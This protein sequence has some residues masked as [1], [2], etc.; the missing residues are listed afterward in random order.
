M[1][2]NTTS[3]DDIREIRRLME[4][5]SRFLSLSGLSG[6]VAGLIALLGAGAAWWYLDEGNLSSAENFR[7]MNYP[8]NVQVI[9][10]LIY[11]ALIVLALALLSG[12]YFSKRKAR[13]MGVK[14]WNSA[15]RKMIINLFIP[16]VTGGLV[17]IVLILRSD[18]NYLAPFTLV[19]Y[20]LGLVNSGKYSYTYIN[21]L[22]ISE[23]ILGIL[24]LVFINHGLLFWAAGFG[25]LHIIYGLVLYNKYERVK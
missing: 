3:L 11:D 21:Y 4:Q 10:F 8:E 12:Y 6:V 18:L 9:R 17:I 14:F 13:R 7:M 24:A 1:E 19:F 16:L 25:V 2:S 20:G 15:A 23:I 5:S 22:G